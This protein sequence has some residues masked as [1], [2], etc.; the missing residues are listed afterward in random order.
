MIEIKFYG[1][2][3]DNIEVEGPCIAFNRDELLDSEEYPCFEDRGVDGFKG[4][5]YI[6]DGASNAVLASISVFYGG[7]EGT[8][9]FVVDDEPVLPEHWSFT[10]GQ[11]KEC[12]YSEE[13]VIV[14]DDD[15][16]VQ[17]EYQ[18]DD[19]E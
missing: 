7:D 9:F 3:D 17:Y 1:Y 2:S 11:S 13:L 4:H 12:D 14:V 6:K 8:W 18:V 19:E 5:M 16:Y 10:I 15:C